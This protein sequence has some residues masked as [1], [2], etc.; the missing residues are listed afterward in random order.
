MIVLA[1]S[2]LMASPLDAPEAEQITD[3]VKREAEFKISARLLAKALIV[4]GR[5]G[6]SAEMSQLI[7]V[8]AVEIK[9]LSAASAIAVAEAYSAWGKGLHPAGLNCEDCFTRVAAKSHGA[10]LHC[11][12]GEITHTDVCSALSCCPRR[13]LF[14][15]T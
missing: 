12:G 11:G 1:T 2:A 6:I 14:L 3:P 7:E 9:T 5:R 15:A 13:V 10:P 8:I 4:A